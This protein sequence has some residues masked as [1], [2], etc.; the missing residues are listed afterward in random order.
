MSVDP[1]ARLRMDAGASE[2]LPPFEL[3]RP[4][5]GW[6]VGEGVESRAA[7]F[8]P[9]D[10]VLHQLGWREYAVVPVD[11]GGR[12][13][14]ERIDVDDATPPRAYLGPPG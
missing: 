9:G 10:H 6:A 12:M 13:P 1:S 11:G 2:N 3:G 4:L 8:A 5:E 14:P 7:G